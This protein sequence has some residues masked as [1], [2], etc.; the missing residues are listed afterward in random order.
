MLKKMN[1]GMWPLYYTTNW[2]N[3]NEIQDYEKAAIYYLLKNEDVWK[4]WV[5]AEAYDKIKA[6]VDAY[7]P[8]P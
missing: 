1:V 2:S 5:T 3:E 4:T 6:A 8:V 7:G